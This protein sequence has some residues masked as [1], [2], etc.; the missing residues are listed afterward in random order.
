MLSHVLKCSC[1]FRLDGLVF[2]STSNIVSP[3]TILTCGLYAIFGRLL[4]EDLLSLINV[5]FQLELHY[6]VVSRVLSL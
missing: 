2:D 3:V 4:S 1:L 6:L 5:G